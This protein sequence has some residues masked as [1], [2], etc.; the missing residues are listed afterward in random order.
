MGKISLHTKPWLLSNS[1]INPISRTKENDYSNL[2]KVFEK[3]LSFYKL[4][5]FKGETENSYEPSL[6]MTHPRPTASLGTGFQGRKLRENQ[7]NTDQVTFNCNVA[8]TGRSVINYPSLK[9]RKSRNTGGRSV[10]WGVITW[11]QCCC[12]LLRLRGDEAPRGLFSE[13]F[14]RIWS[15]RC[16]P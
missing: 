3:G 5:T 7:K 9:C 13:G 14:S 11:T 12:L 6:N 10:L 2:F 1:Q 16:K 4:N 8:V 15:C